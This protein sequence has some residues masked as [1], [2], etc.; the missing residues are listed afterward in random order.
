V[1]AVLSVQRT[2]DFHYVN[3]GPQRLQDLLG[4][5]LAKAEGIVF[6]QLFEVRLDLVHQPVPNSGIYLDI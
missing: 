5:I 2:Q 6:I 4:F 1:F 3:A